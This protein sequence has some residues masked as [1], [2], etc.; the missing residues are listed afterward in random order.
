MI[1][2]MPRVRLTTLIAALVLSSTSCT[3][4]TGKSIYCDRDLAVSGAVNGVEVAEDDYSMQSIWFNSSVEEEAINDLDAAMMEEMGLDPDDPE[5]VTR[6]RYFTTAY[7]HRVLLVE[8]LSNTDYGSLGGE[9]GKDFGVFFF[10]LE[11]HATQPG[12]AVAVF[13]ASAIHTLRDAGDTG[14]L[15]DAVR[16]ILD[17]MQQN[18]QPDALVA[19][20]ADRS[21][22]STVEST[23]IVL[24]SRNATYASGGSAVF[25]EVVSLD[26]DD[27]SSIR[28]PTDDIDAMSLSAGVT[29][30]ADTV[31]VDATCLKV[32]VS[33]EAD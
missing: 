10:D 24:L 29:F 20:A 7:D 22:E 3:I 16:S 5:D 2:T 26:G 30:G 13:D 8:E 15:G 32:G 14:A 19:F 18:D 31:S 23:L 9:T 25:H 11:A 17:E 1:K 21:A 12:D 27:V 6:Y 33:G 4:D 28:Y